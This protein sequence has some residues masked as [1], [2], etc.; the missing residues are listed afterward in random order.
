MKKHLFLTLL[1]A[2]LL[3]FSVGANAKSITET[4]PVVNYTGLLVGLDNG[5]YSPE[6]ESSVNQVIA[7]AA[8]LH[9]V[10]NG[11]GIESGYDIEEYRSY[12][13]E[14]GIIYEGLFDDYTRGATRAE[15]I[16]CLSKA[17]PQSVLQPEI[18]TISYIPDCDP[19]AGYYEP[20]ISFYK[21]GIVT[22][23]GK[24][25]SFRPGASITNK[26]FASILQR[27]VTPDIRQSASFEEYRSDA[28][29]YLIDDFFLTGTVRSI[30]NIA[31]G[32]RYDYTGSLFAGEENAYSSSLNDVS[33]TDNI[34]ISRRVF[35]QSDGVVVLETSFT[36]SQ[37]KNGIVISLD[38]EEG[39]PIFTL[40]T[41]NDKFYSC[42]EGGADKQTS[43][44]AI[45]AFAEEISINNYVYKIRMELDL[46]GGTAKAHVGG[47]LIG[48]HRLVAGYDNVARVTISTGI[49]ETTLLNV[50]NAHM[51]KNYR[52][53]D[54]MRVEKTGDKPFGYE[55]VGDV[56]VQLLNGSNGNSGVD[57][58]SVKINAKA[59]EKAYAKKSFT[60]ASGTVK[61]EAYML[62]PTEDDGAYFTATYKGYPVFTIETK[63]GSFYYGNRELYDFSANIWQCLHVEADTDKQTFLLRINGKEIAS[64]L[65]FTNKVPA[66]DGFEI[67]I[68]AEDDC[69]MWFDDVEIYELYEYEDYVPVPQKL[70]SDYYVSM[71]VCN[72]WRNGSHYGWEYIAPHNDLLP[73]TGFYDEGEPEAMDWE[74]KFLAE[75]GVSFYNMCWY[76]PSSPQLNPIKRPKMVD[77]FHDGYFNAKYSDML[78]F[79]IM[80]EN[81]SYGTPNTYE[82]FLENVWPFWLEWYLKDDRYFTIDNKP[83]IV[84]YNYSYWLTMCQEKAITSDMSAAEQEEIRQ[85]AIAT[86]KTVHD[87]MERDLIEAGYDGIILTFNNRGNSESVASA[88]LG[89]G[90]DGV[91]P[92]N[93][94]TSGNTLSRNKTL[95]DSTYTE[96]EKYGIDLLAVAGIGFNHI[97][98]KLER[99]DLISVEEYEELLYWFRDDY[100]KRF[101]TKYANDPDNLWKSKFI[102]LATWNEFGEGHYL[103]PSNLHGYGYLDA[104]A[105]VFGKGSHDEELDIMPT[106]EQKARI[107]HLYPDYDHFIRREHYIKT[108]IKI[109]DIKEVTYDFTTKTA[110]SDLKL[111]AHNFASTPAYTALSNGDTVLA[112]TSNGNDPQIS[113]SPET[114]LTASKYEVI[115]VRLSVSKPGTTGVIYYQREDIGKMSE[116]YKFTFEI[117]DTGVQDY[118]IP[119]STSTNWYGKINRLRIDP[120]SLTGNEVHFYSLDLMNYSNALKGVEISIDKKPFGF[121]TY[122]EIQEYNN[123]EVYIASTEE[124]NLYRKLHI[125]YDWNVN[126][127]KLRLET[128]N[129]TVFDFE[130]GSKTVLVNGKAVTLEKKVELF[131][132]CPVV[133]LIFILKNADYKFVYDFTNKLLEITSIDVT[134]IYVDFD[135]G[136]AESEYVTD[137]FYN[138]INGENLVQ[139]VTDPERDDN[140]VWYVKADEGK[141]W[142]Y[143]RA[144]MPFAAGKT[145]TVDF[146]IKLGK[147][148]T[149]SI[150]YDALDVM[151]NPRYANTSQLETATDNL[152]DHQEVAGQI[153]YSDGWTHIS[154]TFTIA[155]DY[156]TTDINGNPYNDTI[157]IYMNPAKI[158]SSYQVGVDYYIDN[159][160]V[161]TSIDTVS[162]INGDAEDD[163]MSFVVLP[164]NATISIETETLSDGTQNR[165][166]RVSPKSSAASQWLYYIQYSEFVPGATYYYEV[167]MKLGKDGAGNDVTSTVSLNARYYDAFQQDN[168]TNKNEHSYTIG[169]MTTGGDWIHYEGS[170][171][172]SYGHEN[173]YVG[174]SGGKHI[175]TMISFYSNPERYEDGSYGPGVEYMFDNFKIYTEKPDHFE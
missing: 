96:A 27:L 32:W 111:S 62:L 37:N 160:I 175:K 67:G 104:V 174:D 45:S 91:F 31:S 158:T 148:N 74:I 161:R 5:M 59:N 10:Y 21:A 154:R 118:Y 103:Y 15:T 136:D 140:H 54:N 23:Y 98:W 95:A 50:K 162:V 86:A 85:N 75:H 40:G 168:K 65:P 77:A 17:V 51:Y 26:D 155:E 107:G 78:D 30:Q 14:K 8:R 80:F 173:Y 102:Q 106:D 84:I 114:P 76:A 28:V 11:T 133:P 93:W 87:K 9:G 82:S 22:G 64:D 97:G 44:D 73:Y 19:S 41:E 81:S 29:F 135:G 153:S 16:Y 157:N 101:E 123:H 47:S 94:G 83:F 170:F 34:S 129:E 116:D 92:Y 39:I 149:G 7:E 105:K 66:F 166:W 115:H 150:I 55:T 60:E 63:N 171:T 119:T 117:L 169:K 120:G 68:E 167:D 38:N 128:P 70:E 12:A 18:N 71:S 52:V 134:T 163:D 79:T 58:N 99:V 159:F 144:D 100:M 110:Y 72:L 42:T 112:A 61:L 141:T 20:L 43:G 1:L 122:D 109:P 139:R 24:Y 33:A 143:F 146:D 57:G 156:I 49:E 56:T 36:V 113:W 138:Y 53:N 25:G 172:I 130:I 121:L 147:L 137:T 88:C 132:G 124:D 131:D 69:T 90:A 164:S 89:M 48:S 145:Y 127:G 142:N 2:A 151:V 126:T 125:V 6:D 108:T 35:P 13:L 165:Y 46:D 3:L 152:Y 4:E